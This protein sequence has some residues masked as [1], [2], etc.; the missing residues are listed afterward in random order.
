MAHDIS[1]VFDC[2]DPDRV[3]RFW[4][5]ALD[6]YDYPGSDPDGPPGSPPAG[7]AT[8]EDWADSLGIPEELR[9]QSRTIIDAT[10]NR[11]DIFFMAVPEDKV[12]KNRVHI[13]IRAA[14]DLPRDAKAATQDAESERLTSIGAALLGRVNNPDGTSHLVMQDVEG[15]EFCIT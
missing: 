7:F 3:A 12:V 15:N 6:G 13:D 11:P 5:A 1:I 10:G 8:W 9:Y 4:M 2:H 14:R